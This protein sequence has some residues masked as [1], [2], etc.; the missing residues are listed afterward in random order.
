MDSLAPRA[1]DPKSIDF[2]GRLH[3][4]G[5]LKVGFDHLPGGLFRL[6]P[7]VTAR[8]PPPPERRVVHLGHL[9]LREVARGCRGDGQDSPES[10]WP[11]HGGRILGEGADSSEPGRA[12]RSG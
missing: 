1:Q 11:R 12:A 6:G 10:F 9:P 5:K 7:V 4:V 2:L 3:S 8:R